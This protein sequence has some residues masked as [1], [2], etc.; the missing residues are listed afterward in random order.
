MSIQTSVFSILSHR[1]QNLV[2]VFH[3]PDCGKIYHFG[4]YRIQTGDK[5]LCHRETTECPFCGKAG[6]PFPQLFNST[7]DVSVF[8]KKLGGG[9]HLEMA[10][11]PITSVEMAFADPEYFHLKR[12]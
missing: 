2:T 4:K 10:L 6:L 8:Y 9:A 3:C 1:M 12:Q 7:E 11:A 5:L